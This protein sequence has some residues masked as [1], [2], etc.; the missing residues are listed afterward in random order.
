MYPIR[1]SP[2]PGRLENVTALLGLTRV[3][4]KEIKT[5]PSLEMSMGCL[6]HHLGP[7]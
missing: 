3:E 5:I 6:L 4:E 2:F 1:C 7:R